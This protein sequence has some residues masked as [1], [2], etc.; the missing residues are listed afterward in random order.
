[1]LLDVVTK[2]DLEQVKTDLIAAVKEAVTQAGGSMSKK[3]LKS[4]EVMDKLSLSASGLQ[5]LR[6]NGT[7]PYSRLG[8]VI[9]Y[10][11]SEIEKILEKN[12]SKLS[13]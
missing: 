11:N 4:T 7:I 13:A 9:Y 6:I 12:K 10:D 3:W 2:S 1:M 8:G 5:N